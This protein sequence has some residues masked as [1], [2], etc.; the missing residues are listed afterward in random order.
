MEINTNL[1]EFISKCP[2]WQMGVLYFFAQMIGALV[3]Y[4]L[5]KAVTPVN[6]AEKNCG[7]FGFC[8]IV[9]HQEVNEIQAFT[10]EFIATA[11]LITVCC[12]VWDSRNAKNQDSVA[13]KFGALITFLSFIFVSFC[14]LL[15]LLL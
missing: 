4:G 2:N 7:S 5:L 14:L 1:Y 10:I 6:I 11:V 13:L 15:L 3:G 12:A 8:A 9:P